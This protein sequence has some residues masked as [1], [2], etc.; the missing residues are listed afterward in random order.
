MLH[1]ADIINHTKDRAEMAHAEHEVIINKP[2]GEVFNFLADGLNN[3]KWRPEVIRISL[4]S[5]QSGQVGAR[6][7][8]TLKG[9]GGRNISGDYQITVSVPEKELAF[10]VTSG[11]ARPTGRFIF[12]HTQTGTKV[13]FVLDYQP[14]GF[15]KLLGPVI[16][17]TMVRETGSLDT[18]KRMLER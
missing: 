12:E 5:G 11:P 3:P 17:K 6:Y 18:L 1:Y 13:T 10:I 15:A 8:Q 2:T 9:P 14:S 7:S 4:N 16:Q